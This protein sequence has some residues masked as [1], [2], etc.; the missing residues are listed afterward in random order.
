[1]SRKHPSHYYPELTQDRLETLAKG[2]LDVYYD[3]IQT[4]ST[5]LDDGYTRGTGTFGRQRQFLIQ[6]ALSDEYP[7]LELAHAGMD[8]TVRIGGVPVRFF[9]D[10]H[11]TPRKKGY[12]RLNA[13]DGLFAPNNVTPVLWRFVIEKALTKEAEDRVFF[14]GHNAAQEV[15]CEW[16]YGMSYAGKMQ[17]SQTFAPAKQSRPT[18]SPRVETSQEASE[19]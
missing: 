13:V 15:I 7:W 14:L 18:T 2:L 5:A 9:A 1:M 8:V 3:T 16:E 6:M 11:E 12:F 10:D 19:R 4:L 17:S